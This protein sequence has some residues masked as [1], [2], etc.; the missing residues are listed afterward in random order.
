MIELLCIFGG[1]CGGFLFGLAAARW[2][3]QPDVRFFG[4]AACQNC[5]GSGGVPVLV[6]DG[7]ATPNPSNRATIRRCKSCRGTGLRASFLRAVWSQIRIEQMTPRTTGTDY[8][9]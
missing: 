5:E 1:T 9:N 7:L 6:T 8:S 4:R 3:L 2:L